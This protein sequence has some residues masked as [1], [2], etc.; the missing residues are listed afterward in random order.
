ELTAD[1]NNSATTISVKHNN[2][3]SGDRIFLEGDGQFE[4]MAV[5][6]GP[7]GAGPY[8]YSVT[9]NLDG[10]G[11]NAWPAGSAVLNT[12]TTGDGF[13]DL[14]ADSGVVTGSTAGPTIVGNV[15]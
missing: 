3:A 12:G 10:S 5:T 4:A 13:I 9:R 14:Y 1:L 2:L 11:A 6:S 15:R 7:S 8:T